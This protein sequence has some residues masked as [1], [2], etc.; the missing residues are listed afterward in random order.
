M[1][2]FGQ[3]LAGAGR[4]SQGIEGARAVRQENEAAAQRLQMNRM[5][6]EEL[7]RL[8]GERVRKSQLPSTIGDI[9]FGPGDYESMPI[10]EVPE[11]AP[12]TTAPAT[13]ST[14]AGIKI[15]TVT[16]GVTTPTAGVKT[17]T[18]LPPPN[19]KLTKKE[20]EIETALQRGAKVTDLETILDGDEEGLAYL[21]SRVQ[22]PTT[23][24]IPYGEEF[25]QDQ[26]APRTGL[27]GMTYEERVKYFQ[28]IDPRYT[29]N[30]ITEFFT[31]RQRDMVQQLIDKR[32]SGTPLTQKELG[33]LN[34]YGPK[35]PEL[36]PTPKTVG[37]KPPPAVETAPTQA[38]PML[39]PFN[40]SKHKP[41]D[42]GLGGLSTEY[43]VTQDAPD[44]SVWVIP[45]IWWDQNGEPMLIKDQAQIQRLAQ[46]YEAAT[47]ALFPRFGK[48]DYKTA[49]AWARQ[50]SSAGGASAVPLVN[51]VMP[52][53]EDIPV[54]VAGIDVGTK[55]DPI[56]SIA[57]GRP[58]SFQADPTKYT[59]ALAQGM[60]NREHLRQLATIYRQSGSPD[61]AFEVEA[62]IQSLDT[63][64]YKMAADQAITEFQY[65]GD[66]ARMMNLIQQLSNVPMDIQYRTDGLYNVYVNGNMQEQPLDVIS[67]TDVLRTFADDAYRIKKTDAQLEN[68]KEILKAQLETEKEIMK[69]NAQMVREAAIAHINR[70]SNA[71]LEQLKQRGFIITN[72]NDGR[73]VI[74]AKDGSI[75]GLVDL[76]NNVEIVDGVEVPLIPKVQPFKFE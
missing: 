52:Q 69:Q 8:E 25:Y 27:G 2:N 48:G 16:S 44:G 76:T 7:R 58:R 55:K 41:K 66:P 15:P 45:S 59:P 6:L 11:Q 43:L 56:E 9:S 71:Y 65:G 12:A 54:P 62:R 18:L 73:V 49:D 31:G 26:Q 14:T 29:K 3:L 10:Y 75:V 57:K 24:E 72:L 68:Q 40:P 34:E 30:P 37:A 35:F 33:I 67:L 17:T 61:K 20:Q 70:A 46:E 21:R 4:V 23:A 47:G 64:L 39:E 50:R 5:R 32:A 74:S 19:R 53:E 13:T 1:S 22:E 63:D 28:S 51:A 38:E 42:V 36:Q 60:R